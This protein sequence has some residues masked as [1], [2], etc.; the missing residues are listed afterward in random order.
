MHNLLD[1]ANTMKRLQDELFAAKY[2]V[3]ESDRESFERAMDKCDKEIMTLQHLGFTQV[4]EALISH[5]YALEDEL[6]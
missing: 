4:A 5:L 3:Q 6:I 1:L 2:H